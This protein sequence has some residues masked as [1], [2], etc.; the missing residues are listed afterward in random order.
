VDGD[1]L[2]DQC[3]KDADSDYVAVQEDVD[4]NG[5]GDQFD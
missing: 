2:G 5:P 4:D 1:G 3:D